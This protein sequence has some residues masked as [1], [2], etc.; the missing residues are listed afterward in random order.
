MI[1]WIYEFAFVDLGVYVYAWTRYEQLQ[2]FNL[3][4]E[5]RV[6][7]LSLHPICCSMDDSLDTSVGINKCLREY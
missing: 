7:L 3:Y 2:S 6:A 1:V 4:A 5:F